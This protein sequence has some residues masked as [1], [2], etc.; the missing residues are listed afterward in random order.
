LTSPSSADSQAGRGLKRL[1]RNIILAMIQAV[2]AIVVMLLA[3]RILITHAG[4]ERLGLWSLLLSGS[5]GARL[6][7]ISGGAALA[8][9]IAEDDAR[10]QDGAIPATVH[11]IVLTNI[12]FNLLACALLYGASQLWLEQFVGAASLNE[13]TALVPIALLG[14]VFLG[15]LS[16][17]LSNALDGRHRADLRAMLTL[18]SL[19]IFLLS[20]W[21][22]VPKMGLL[23][24]GWA[25]VIQNTSL[26]VMCWLCL[27]RLI[28][29]IGWLPY[30]WDPAVFLRT[31][32][33]GLSLQVYS[34]AALLS[35][36]VAK[37][38]F[39]VFGGLHAVAI[40][41]LVSR[42]VLG[43]RSIAVQ[44][45]QPLMPTFAAH[46]D[47]ADTT[48]ALLKRSTTLISLAALAVFVGVFSVAPLYVALLN[49]EIDLLFI[50]ILLPFT[51]GSAVNLIAVGFY[52]ASIGH[53][54]MFWNIT[55]QVFAA[56]SILL[57]GQLLGHSMGS[58]GVI[59][60]VTIGFCLNSL[61]MLIGNAWALN[62][63]PTLC[64]L[65]PPT[66]VIV[67]I[68]ALGLYVA[69]EYLE[70][71]SRV[72]AAIVGFTELLL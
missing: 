38:Y 62:Q 21:A 13:A 68:M 46:Q 59:L 55:A 7:D 10:G 6:I 48:A 37:F 64:R 33:F 32:K 5:V 15:Q 19:F 9:F 40:Y 3:Y 47:H 67:G 34:I 30:R 72:L 65:G 42:L 31:I 16:L 52:Y 23:G 28:V 11:T 27:R 70:F 2:S 24:F 50:M 49:I 12:G 14:S 53:G 51:F 18:V 36:P 26:L 29:G 22:L 71:A 66:M 1:N 43:L 4:I 56:I 41:E 8:K 45:I 25:L 20:A 39:S 60:A 35:D 61:I 58:Q 57:L 44:A 17:V 69:S 63:V 54:K